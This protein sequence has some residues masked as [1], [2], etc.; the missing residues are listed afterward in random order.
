MI[1]QPPHRGSCAVEFVA[2][3]LPMTPRRRIALGLVAMALP[4]V[5]VAVGAEQSGGTPTRNEII[6]KIKSDPQ[7]ADT[8]DAAAG[9]IADWYLKYATPQERAAFV[10]GRPD[11]AMAEVAASP[12]AREA[13]LD[14]LKRATDKSS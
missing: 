3:P 9:C 1:C 5:L 13:I 11:G 6:A 4:A 12:Q 8:P 10:E 2:Y 7:M 14:C